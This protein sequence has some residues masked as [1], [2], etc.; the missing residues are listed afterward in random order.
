MEFKTTPKRWHKRTPWVIWSHWD[1]GSTLGS[2]IL[3]RRKKSCQFSSLSITT[4]F[5]TFM[6]RAPWPVRH[7]QSLQKEP[8]FTLSWFHAWLY[9]SFDNASTDKLLLNNPP[10]ASRLFWKRHAGAERSEQKRSSHWD[11]YET[12]RI[13][14]HSEDYQAWMPLL[15]SL[16]GQYEMMISQ[17]A[18]FISKAPI[19]YGPRFLPENGV[20]LLSLSSSLKSKA[21]MAQSA[22][23][24][25]AKAYPPKFNIAPEKLPSQ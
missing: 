19:V 6:S 3:L 4:I 24:L 16:L 7:H 5:F 17:F 13:R 14:P 2:S 8:I 21:A 10:M 23:D 20:S 1:I 15:G 9:G 11:A 18:L 22:L 12:F 25:R